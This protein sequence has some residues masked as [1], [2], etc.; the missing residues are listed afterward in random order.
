MK[1]RTEKPCLDQG[2]IV[3][4]FKSLDS[5]GIQA[6]MEEQAKQ[7]ALAFGLELLELWTPWSSAESAIGILRGG[8]TGV[9]GQR[10]RRLWWAGLVSE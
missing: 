8:S 1:K 4:V 6:V 5:E 3:S 2:K 10:R 9:T 7:A